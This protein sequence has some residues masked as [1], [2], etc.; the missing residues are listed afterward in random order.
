MVFL[1]R[2]LVTMKILY[3]EEF[4]VSRSPHF[5]AIAAVASAEVS[6]NAQSACSIDAEIA[7][8]LAN[9]G[10]KTPVMNSGILS[11]ATRKYMCTKLTVMM[12]KRP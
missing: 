11:Q 1:A 2:N 4:A 12:E 3:Q 5:F 9:Y 10:S 7:F 8:L 6:F